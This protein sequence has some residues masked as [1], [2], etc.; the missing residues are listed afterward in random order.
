[1]FGRQK[2]ATYLAEFIGAGVLTLI[3]L[4][5]KISSLGGLAFFVACATGLAFIAMSLVLTQNSGAHFNPALTIAA[6]TVKKISTLNAVFYIAFQLL[7]A[8]A[9]YSLY[10]Y[11]I[12]QKLNDN[13]GNFT[14]RVFTAE[15]VGAGI[16][17]F[18]FAAA[19][20]QGFSRSLS[21]VVAGLGL[22]VGTVVATASSVS[23]GLLNPAVA[24]GLKTWVWTTYVAAPVV[25]AIVGFNLYYRLFT[26]EGYKKLAALFSSTPSTKA[27]S[28]KKL[29]AK[30]KAAPKRKK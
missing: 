10:I 8:F 11:F 13:P 25:G 4:S 7:G 15:A 14:G 21:S 16:F 22:I 2:I 23:L 24:L 30:K 19:L 28:A 1:M 20:Y 18:A 12:G 6:W 5:V 29:V 9:A 27:V 17:A 3:I 26:D